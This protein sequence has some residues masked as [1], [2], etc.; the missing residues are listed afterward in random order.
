MQGRIR[1]AEKPR[2]PQDRDQAP[3]GMFRETAR[4]SVGGMGRRPEW[5][6][7][8]GRVKAG[9]KRAEA[10]SC[11]ERQQQKVICSFQNRSRNQVTFDRARWS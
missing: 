8:C 2:E 5:R 10:T 11:T 3:R 4:G 9:P 6:P 7:W 1:Q